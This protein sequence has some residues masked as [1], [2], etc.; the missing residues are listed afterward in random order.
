MCHPVCHIGIWD[1][2]AQRCREDYRH[3]ESSGEFPESVSEDPHP[4]FLGEK[5][6][7]SLGEQTS[8]CILEVKFP[9]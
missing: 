6:L 9:L 2:S 8:F 1:T 5:Q 7:M 3:S 4:V